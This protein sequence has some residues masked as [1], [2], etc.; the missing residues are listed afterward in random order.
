MARQ[1]TVT[2]W[3]E[4]IDRSGPVQISPG[5]WWVG[6]HDSISG[7]HCNA[8]LIVDGDEAVLLN[9]GSRPDFP[10]VMLKILQ[11]GIYPTQIRTLI[12][13]H[14]DPDVCG[15]VPQL[16]ELIGHENLQIIS[17]RPNHMFIRHYAVNSRLRSLAEM[18]ARF[19]F[20]SGR[21]LRFLPIP[22]CHSAGS[23]MIYDE[24]SQILFSGDLFGSSGKSEQLYVQ[25][26]SDCADCP[27]GDQCP[28][29]RPRCPITGITS[30]HRWLIP[31]RDCLEYS[32]EQVRTVDFQV[33]APQHGGILPDR[34]SAYMVMERIE[35]MEKVGIEAIRQIGWR[36]LWESL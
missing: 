4:G 13:D 34:E 5:I 32:L 33:I 18:D 17:S 35:K 3:N 8:Y 24:Q 20:S 26:Y 16:E 31:S 7:L 9:G 11:T 21:T 19:C 22:Y 15:S 29:G 14:Y 10:T 12:Y 30:F 28:R 1:K 36:K 2:D 6:F 25:L 27:Q 23:M